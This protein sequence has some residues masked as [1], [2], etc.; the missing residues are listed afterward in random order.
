MRP[1]LIVERKHRLL[2]AVLLHHEIILRQSPH[3][4]SLL[5]RHHHVHRNPPYVQLKDRLLRRGQ[6]IVFPILR[7]LS[8]RL[9]LGRRR[10]RRH[11]SLEAIST[12]LVM[13]GS[14]GLDFETRGTT[15]LN[16]GNRGVGLLSINQPTPQPPAPASPPAPSRRANRSS[17]SPA[18]ESPQHGKTGSPVAST[19]PEGRIAAASPAPGP[20]S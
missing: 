4:I 20:A 14:P 12:L 1:I 10:F 11:H 18:S 19:G 17:P 3:R 16:P 6:R 7:S 13:L 8:T 15:N 9:R 2:F 5:V